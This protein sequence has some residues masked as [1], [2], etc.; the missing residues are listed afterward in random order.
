MDLKEPTRRRLL[1]TL[2][3]IGFAVAASS[4]SVRGAAGTGG[5]GPAARP[6]PTPA[7]S[8]SR[9]LRAAGGPHAPGR[10]PVVTPAVIL[11]GH[12]AWK[13]TPAPRRK[14]AVTNLRELG[15]GRPPGT[16]SLTIDDGPHP[17]YT[18]QILDLLAEHRVTATF[19]VVGEMVRE[20][21]LITRRIVEAGHQICNHTMSHPSP[22]D[23]IGSRRIRREIAEAHERI[24]Q[25]TGVTPKFFRAPGG[26]WS[27]Q[28]FETTAEFGMIPIGWEVDP[29]DWRR[30][31]VGRIRRALLES[32]EGAIMLCH[33]GGG[34]RSQTVAA[35]R[36][37]LPRLKKRGLTFVPL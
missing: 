5:R 8:G 2:G 23:R 17:E 3:A 10:P 14:E 15:P 29:Q 7:P 24:A 25:A 36:Q 21:P 35:L 31:G 26:A 20:Y 33:D 4:D 6:T 11:P 19:F 37:V 30:P 32:K 16:I 12:P 1:W 34:D 18:P 27:K 13:P 9:P 28:V 22:F